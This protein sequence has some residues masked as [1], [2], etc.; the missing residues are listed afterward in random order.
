MTSHTRIARFLAF[1]LLLSVGLAFLFLLRPVHTHAHTAIQSDDPTRSLNEANHL[2]WLGNWYAAAALYQKAE[3]KFRSVGDV[4]NEAYAHIGVI[5]AQAVQRPSDQVLLALDVELKAPAVNHNLRLRMWGLAQR[6]AIEIDID[7]NAAKRDWTEVRDLATRL[8]EKQWTARADG[9]LG[10]VAFLKGDTAEA[11]SLLGKSIFSAYRSSDTACQIRLLSLLGLGF[12]EEQRYSEALTL[13][14]YAIG[15]ANGN[16]NIGFPFLA[17]RGE[18]AALAGLGQSDKATQVLGTALNAAR[19]QNDR[20]H[21]ADLLIEAGRVAIDQSDLATAETTL[22]QAGRIAHELNLYRDLDEAMFEL[23]KVERQ[24]GKTQAAVRAVQIALKA[25]SQLGERYYL[26]RDFTALAEIKLVQ[27]KLIEADKLFGAAE[28]VLDGILVNE[29]SFEESTARAGSMSSTYL[30]HFRLAVTMGRKERAFQVLERVR[31]RTVASKLF[32]RDQAGARSPRIE[33]LNGEIAATQLALLHIDD[34]KRRSDLMEQLLADERKLAFELNEAGL[35]RKDTLPLPATLREVQGGLRNDEVLTEYVLDEPRAFCIAL[36]RTA[37]Q[38]VALPAGKNQ[39]ETLT[40]SYLSEL[41]AK[42]MGKQSAMD[43]YG[44][45]VEP[46]LSRFPESHLII[47]PDGILNSLPFEAL[48]NNAGY[49]IQSKVI[50]YTP[51]GTVLW[52]LRST[53]PVK[54][55][56]PLLAVGAVDYHLMRALPQAYSANAITATVLRG[57]SELS[58]SKL[59]DL[60][61]SRE[62]VLTIG[63]IAGSDSK[64]LLGESATETEFKKQNLGQFRVIHLATHATADRQYPDRAALLL[65][66]APNS[67]DDGLLQLREIMHLSLNADLVTLSACETEVGTNQGEAGVV[68]LEQAFLIAGARAVVASLWNVEDS[69]TTMLMKSFYEHLAHHEDKAVALA[70]AK[71]DILEKYPDV[72]PYYW[73]AFV[74]VGQGAEQVPFGN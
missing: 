42:A 47:S 1:V 64:L 74:M 8:G 20:V 22:R 44:L 70:H 57:L 26:P 28:D 49:L 61:G 39:I 52:R 71:L 30:E 9:E 35:Q 54:S 58:G 27:G 3:A 45:L 43:L 62:E 21:E 13:F 53:E 17:F 67:A 31:G 56:Q 10:L 69:S 72:P 63:R 60:P 50:S 15:T 12:N 19:S 38:I 14:K 65:A 25:S 33:Q 11:V 48:M 6:A 7:S 5:R 36:S 4:E 68:N 18:A 16:P 55:A 2:A 37:V 66:P 41:K 29:H 73:A 51:S 59:E 23:A 46:L 34:K 24:L 32:V 40:K